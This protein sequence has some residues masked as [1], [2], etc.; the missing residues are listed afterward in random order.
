MYYYSDEGVPNRSQWHFCHQRPHLVSHSRTLIVKSV[1]WL[2]ADT[3]LPPLKKM[4]KWIFDLFSLVL[5]F[6]SKLSH[7][8]TIPLDPTDKIIQIIIRI[9]YLF[10]RQHFYIKFIISCSH[11][12]LCRD[13]S[14]WWAHRKTVI[15]GSLRIYFKFVSTLPVLT[16][17]DF[18]DWVT[19]Q[20]N[21]F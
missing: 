3:S 20:R 21:A 11:L 14:T 17:L 13:A 7:F 6:V 9:I 8:N 10:D 18:V 12:S 2:G 4:F 1:T 15:V 19:S 5:V 16:R